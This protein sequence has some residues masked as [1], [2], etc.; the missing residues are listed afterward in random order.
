MDSSDDD[1]F[2]SHFAALD[3]L[4]QLIYQGPSKFVV[5]SSVN[6]AGWT[7]HLG[8]T[9]HS[10]RWWK[11][12]WTEK[13]VDKFVVR[14]RISRSSVLA[15]G[16]CKHRDT[17]RASSRTSSLRTLPKHWSTVRLPLEIGVQTKERVSMYVLQSSH[18]EYNSV[19]RGHPF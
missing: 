12:T 17:P 7:V 14:M 15:N 6:D 1:S 18:C 8:L 5:L 3:E 4:V 13:D 10:G 2:S 16:T 11:G 19:K 9:G